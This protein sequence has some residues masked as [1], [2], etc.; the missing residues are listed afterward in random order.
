MKVLISTSQNA[1]NYGAV[2]QS[3]A[4]GR[5]LNNMNIDYSM[6]NYFEKYN[7]YF[8]KC[9]F[10][11]R[12][13]LLSSIL[14]NLYNLA[15]IFS[16]REQLKRFEFFLENNIARTR[17]YKTLEDLQRNPPTADV[18]ITGGDQMFNCHG[19]VGVQGFLRFGDEKIKRYSFSTS[20]GIKEPPKQYLNE[21]ISSLNKFET[22]SL[23]EDSAKKYIDEHCNVK[24]QVNLDPVFLL[25][26]DQW[27]KLIENQPKSYKKPYILVYEL[28]FHPLTEA[29][30]KKVN[31]SN[32]F[33][34]VV[35]SAWA[36]NRIRADK[37]V[38]NAG[39][40]EFINLFVNAEKVVT[41]SFH[42][43]CFS[44]LFEKDFYSLIDEKKEVRISNLL[45]KF[46]LEDKMVTSKLPAST[47]REAFSYSKNII[48][49]E[50]EKA[51]KYL[52]SICGER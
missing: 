10:N 1:I 34:I 47:K 20:M 9:N 43:T 48:N 14:V 25:D 51:K 30:I 38:R 13:E 37:V 45:K 7:L 41:T 28:L 18:Y 19:G 15:Y 3:Y 36:R 49:L 50:R 29:V 6:L 21:F 4:M 32:N 16:K 46:N 11:S 8:S 52:R 44:I 33:D 22:I 42:G 24:S 5:F 31:E 26:K 40:A 23:R 39:P 12:K 27:L 35:L 17:E 2:L